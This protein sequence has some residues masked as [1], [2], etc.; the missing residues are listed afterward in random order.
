MLHGHW[1]VC[2]FWNLRTMLHGHWQ[3]CWLW[4]LRTML[5]G[6]WQVCWFWKLRTA[7]GCKAGTQTHLSLWCQKPTSH[8]GVRNPP[9]TVASET[10]LSLWRQKQALYFYIGVMHLNQWCD[11]AEKAAGSLPENMPVGNII[12]KHI[13]NLYTHKQK[14]RHRHA[15]IMG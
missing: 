1:Q 4:N 15:P 3:V 8:C 7:W 13:L 14:K 5:N 10:H 12:P 6:H 2:W 11:S 9:L